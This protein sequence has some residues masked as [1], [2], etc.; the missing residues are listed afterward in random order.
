MNKRTAKRIETFLPN[1]VPKCVRCYDSGP[2][3]SADRYT[4]VYTGKYRTLGTKRGEAR[5][6]GNF[7]YVGMS[8]SPFHPQG[9][10]QHGEHPNQI[11]VNKSGFAPAIGRKCHLGRRIPF[12][13]LPLDCKTLVMRDYRELWGLPSPLESLTAKLHPSRSAMSPKM[14]SI[15]AYIVGQEWVKPQIN[16]LMVTSDR[17]VMGQVKGDIGLNHFIG[18]ESDLIRNWN[19]LLDCAGLGHDEGA[20]AVKLY[21]DKVRHC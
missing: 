6:L 13:E 14:A 8:A 2:D 15:V 12:V 11:D 3:G 20:L 9:F 18:A 21:A 4:V 1:G 17:F 16:C 7:Q 10:G 19:D 5:T